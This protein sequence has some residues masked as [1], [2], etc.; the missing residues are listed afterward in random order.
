[1][2]IQ[3]IA[4]EE[5]YVL[6]SAQLDMLEG[7]TPLTS[8]QW[9]EFHGRA[10]QIRMLCEEFEASSIEDT[11]QLPVNAFL[12]EGYDALQGWAEEQEH[13]AHCRLRALV[14]PEDAQDAEEELLIFAEA[15]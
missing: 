5:V 2:K 1:M 12:D 14:Q 3:A 11:Q 13:F 8:E 15:A 7:P 10:E 9:A 4:T 6:I